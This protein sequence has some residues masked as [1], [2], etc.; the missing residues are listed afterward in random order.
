M[1]EFAGGITP[2]NPIP[3]HEEYAYTLDAFPMMIAILVLIIWHPGRTLVGPESEFPH[4]SRKEKKALKQERKA[5]KAREKEERRS[6]N[7]DVEI[8]AMSISS[9]VR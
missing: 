1:V 9:P 7:Q 5:R 3:F 6:R 8:V 4:L 2:S